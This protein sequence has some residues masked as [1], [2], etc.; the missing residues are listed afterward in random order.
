MR[1]RAFIVKVVTVS[2]AGIGLITA[3]SALGNFLRS[4]ADWVETGG[5]IELILWSV[6]VV[7]GV[8]M[9]FDIGAWVLSW[10]RNR[11]EKSPQTD[12]VQDPIL[13][14]ALKQ[15]AEAKAR[16]DLVDSKRRTFGYNL[17]TA[18]GGVLGALYKG[19]DK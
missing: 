2:T 5:Q 3:P 15:E 11:S 8:W 7:L 18:L 13:Q 17:N 1:I 19:N 12:P 10:H 14:E 6:I 16:S 4:T 9:I